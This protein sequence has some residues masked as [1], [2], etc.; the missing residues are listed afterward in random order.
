MILLNSTIKSKREVKTASNE[1]E[2]KQHQKSSFYVSIHE[3]E[4]PPQHHP[5]CPV[6]GC[7]TAPTRRPAH[8]QGLLLSAFHWPAMSA[9]ITRER[10]QSSPLSQR[11]R[12]ERDTWWHTSSPPHPPASLQVSL[13]V[14]S[15][16]SWTWTSLWCLHGLSTWKSF[17][18]WPL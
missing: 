13:G 6:E 8:L 11:R 9:P 4:T 16:F 15:C 1:E 7:L 17:L 12:C 14:R 18:H 3:G 2:M 5:W 10:R